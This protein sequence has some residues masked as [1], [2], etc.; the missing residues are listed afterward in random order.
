M[1]RARDVQRA[2]ATPDLDERR[3]CGIDD[4]LVCVFGEPQQRLDRA[5]MPVTPEYTRGTRAREPQPLLEQRH[6]HR[7]RTLAD[8]PERL[9]RQIAEVPRFVTQALDQERQR[10]GVAPLLEAAHVIALAGQPA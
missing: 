10:F 7:R 8:P 4:R 3:S 6:Q 2:T 9:L 1:E 5:G